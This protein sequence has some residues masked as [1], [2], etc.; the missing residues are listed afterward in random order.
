ERATILVPPR[1]RVGASASKTAP[2]RASAMPVALAAVLRQA[3]EMARGASSRRYISWRLFERSDTLLAAALIVGVFILFH[4]PL[5]HL[6]DVAHEFERQYHLDLV[7]PLIVLTAVF[8]FHQYRKGQQ[9][10]AQLATA[11]AEAEQARLRSDELERLVGLGRA[12][13][14]ATDF[15]RL[16]EAFSRF[17]PKFANDRP[18]WLL[19]CH[20]RCWDVLVRGVEDHRG[21]DVLESIA[22]R[23]LA[24]QA[25]GAE[26]ICVEGL[27]CF[28][29]LVGGQPV[30]MIL[31]RETPALSSQECR[32]IEA[33][34]ALGAI[35]I[36]NMQTLIETRENSLRDALTGCFNRAHALETLH[37]ELRRA[38]RG[39]TPLSVIMF[40]ID[41]FKAVNDSYGHLAGDSLLADV[42]K[43]LSELMRTS[44]VKCRYGGD[45]FLLI[46]PDTPAAGARQV[47]ESLRHELS[48]I[49]LPVANA[50]LTI[51]VSVGVVTAAKNEFDA[52]ALIARVD[53]ALYRAKH[54]GRNRVV[55][56]DSDVGG[57]LRL[58]N[59]VS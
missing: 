15:T 6:L 46:L 58:V 54:A 42:G 55:A 25:S 26:T 41:E 44:D 5:R 18:A 39:R 27:A 49:T 3:T 30:G 32:A 16:H 24:A 34:A 12:V 14:M 33:A 8:I 29:M 59:A 28:P 50:T 13:A 22:K 43:R 11:A 35:S 40:D 37:A 31:I 19:V 51:T 9:A 48:R 1:S 36:R 52:R 56:A 21:A 10:K 20:Q 23:A 53:Q 7:Q 47:A 45:E 2:A 57:P 17:L 38:Q 4:Q